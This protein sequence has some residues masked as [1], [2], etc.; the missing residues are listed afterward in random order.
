ME[1]KLQY[2]TRLFKKSTMEKFTEHFCNVIKGVITN[3][4]ITIGDIE[5]L[6]EKE[7]Q[8]IIYDFNDTKTD[9]PKHATM[10]HFFE[11]Q[12]FKSPEKVALK[13]KEK[14]MT[15]IE[16]N[17]KANQLAR[18]LR[19]K[20]VKPNTI[21]GICV[22]RSFEMIIG[23]LG[24]LKAGGAYL[25]IDP[26]YPVERIEFM[27]QDTKAKILL[28]SSH[29]LK[30]VNFAG[31][32][33]VLDDL[34]M[35]AYVSHNLTNYNQP[36]DLA[37]IIYTSGSTG[38][39]KGVMI[40][41]QSIF[42]T[43]KWRTR[44]YQFAEN[45]TIL[46]IPSFAFDSSVEDIFATLISGSKLVLIEQ[47]NRLNLEYLNELMLKNKVT[48]FLITPN[49]YKTLLEEMPD[50]LTNLKAVTLA[51]E[52]FTKELVKD[53]F[54]K[55]Q[56]VRLF[57]EY[58]PTENSVCSTIYEFNPDNIIITIGKPIDNVKCYI[59]NNKNK[60]QPI[61]VSGELCVSGSGLSRGYLNRPVLTEEKFV[62]NPFNSAEKM[63]RTGDLV[64]WLDNGIIEFLGRT[65]HQV[66]IRGFRIELGEIESHLLKH[67]R[68]KNALVIART[69]QNND[70]YLC[71]Y[72]VE[73]SE[74]SVVELRT[75]LTNI[76]PDYMIPQYFIKLD[77]IPLTSN[78]KVDLKALPESTDKIETGI[79]YVAPTNEIEAKLVDFWLEILNVE[80]IGVNDDFF[81]LG[82]YSLKAMQLSAKVSK[83]FNKELPLRVIF[84]SPNIKGLAKYIL[85]VEKSR[86]EN[87]NVVETREYY[88]LSSAQKRLYVLNQLEGK[89]ISY[90]MPSFVYIEGEY[91][92]T[93]CANVF[94]R[95]IKQHEV[96]RSSFI[97]IDGE[98]V[99][100]IYEDVD[101]DIRYAE[102]DENEI[103]K[104]VK[105]FIQPFDLS[106]A[107]LLRVDLLKIK[108]KNK[109]L[110]MID[111]HHIISD[112]LSMEILIEDFIQLHD[113][114]DLPKLKIQYKD[115]SEWQNN[116]L[117]SDEIKV[118]EKFWLDIFSEEIS[119]LNLPTDYL[120]PAVM[121][122]TGSVSKFHIVRDLADQLKELA[123]GSSTTLYMI[124]LAVYNI[125]LAKYAGQEDIVIGSPIANRSHPDLEKIMGMFVNMLAMR[126]YPTEDK[127]FAEF[128][129][130]VKDNALLAYENQ[131]YQFEM[132]VERL[133]LERDLSR[134]PLFDTVFA[135]QNFNFTQKSAG[136]IKFT[137]YPFEN[138]IA[139]FDLT[140]N[141]V[142][143]ENGIDFDIE[144]RT[145]L[146]KDETIKRM[147]Y[148][149]INIIR[150][151]VKNP[152]ISLKDIEII[153]EE[154]K[155]QILF[156][157]NDTYK[158]NPTDKT[159]T[160]LFEEQVKRNP[161]KLALVFENEKITYQ[162][163]NQKSN[164]LAR[165]LREKGVKT[166][167][168]VGIIVRQGIEMFI[169]ILAIL[170]AR[171]AYL[172]IDP[173]YPIERI[174]YMLADS[175]TCLCLSS[176]KSFNK[177]DFAGEIINLDDEELYENDASN[178]EMIKQ[179]NNLAYVIHTSGSTGKPKGVL[180]EHRS[181]LNLIYWHNDYYQVTEADRS[182]KYAGFG[183]D[184]SVWEIFPYIIKGVTI[185]IISEE[186][187]LD[188]KKLSNYFEENQITISFLPTQ[189][190]EQFMNLEIP[191]LRKLLTGGDRLKSYIKRN[192]QLFNNYGPTEDTVVATA[193]EIT[194]DYANIPIGKPIY[195]TQ[196]Y[197]LGNSNQLQPIGIP[198]ELCISGKSL[199]R[200][201]LNREELT[202]EKFTINPYTNERMYRTGD[203]ARWLPDGSIEFLGRVDQQ[204]KIRGY[205]IEPGEIENQI[206]SHEAVREA[207]VVDIADKYD[208]KY[209]VA[210]IIGEISISD[211]KKYLSKELPDYMIPQYFVI[212]EN[213][214]VTAN[215]KIDRKAL[216]RP[217]I[218]SNDNEYIAPGN[219]T[220]EKLAKIWSEVLGVECV[221]I[222]D[223]FFELGGDSIRAIQIVARA[224]Q[225]GH[226]ITVKDIF[227]YKTI[228][229]ILENVDYRK[230]KF[231][232][233]QDDVEGEV[234]LTPIQNW[235]FHQKFTYQHYWNQSNIFSIKDDVDLELLEEVFRKLIKTHDALRMGY[236]FDD[237]QIVQF[238]RRNDE[239]DFE[240]DVID[241]A[242]YSYKVQKEKIKQISEELQN[243]LDLENDLLIKAFIFDLGSNGK[244]LLIP[245]HHLVIDGV[246]WRILL[247]DLEELYQ[248]KLQKTLPLKTTSF[249]EWSSKLNEY[250][251]E[252]N[253]DIEYWE[254]ID[255]S[256]VK[257]LVTTESEH[258]Y[259]K[260]FKRK[261]IQLDETQT[262]ILLT[263]VNFAYN[264]EINDILL[265][266]LAN[267]LM[268]V[269]ESENL[270]LTLEGHGREE[271]IEDVDISR[272]VGWFTSS[273]PVYFERQE[274]IE[275]SIKYVKEN[276]RKIPDRGINCGIARYLQNQSK[277]QQLNPEISFNY[278]GQ[279]DGVIAKNDK[280]ILNDCIEEIG[281]GIHYENSHVNLIDIIGL[282]INGRLELRVDYN[283]K[284]IQDD[285]IADFM[286]LYK[287]QLLNLIDH[288]VNKIESSVTPSDFRAERI[289]DLEGF[290]LI[291]KRYSNILK[292]NPLT[293]MQE[294]MLFHSLS[295]EKG[296]NYCEQIGYFIDG[297]IDIEM[298]K[299]SWTKTLDRHEIFRTE[300]VWKESKKPVQIVLQDKD[301]EIHEHDIS[302]K[303]S[304]EQEKYI[305][306]F[307]NGDLD[308]G[309][310]IN[311]GKL[312]RLS[313][314]KLSEDK[315]YVC[316][317]F[318]HI[319]LDG[320]S[321]PVVIQSLLEIYYALTTDTKM[322]A[323]S[324]VDFSDY[325]EWYKKHDWRKSK[326]FWKDYLHDF[327][328]PTL[329]PVDKNVSNKEVIT[330]AETVQLEFD[331]E[332]TAKINQ[333]CKKKNITMNALIQTAWGILL[334]KYNN[335]DKSCFGMTVSGRPGEIDGV[336]NIVGLFI[337]TLP[338]VVRNKDGYRIKEMLTDLN[339]ELVEIRE[340]GYISLTEIQKVSNI[341]NSQSLF[342][343]LLVYEN[344][345]LSSVKVKDVG[346]NISFNSIYSLTNYDLAVVVGSNERTTIKLTYNT[347][348]FDSTDIN[349]ISSYLANLIDKTLK[350]PELLVSEL[351]MIGEDEKHDLVVKFNDTKA[352]YP[353]EKTIQQLF[354]ECVDKTP[355][356]IAVIYN[357]QRYTY[358]ELN[359][360]ANYL[361]QVL[362]DKGVCQESVVGILVGHSVEMVVGILGI[363]KVGGVYLPIDLDYPDERIDYML[364]DSG[365]EILLTQSEL[366]KVSNI[367]ID[368]VFLDTLVYADESQNLHQV[369]NQSNLAYIIYTSG[370]TGKPKGVAIEHQ[371]VVNY[372][373]WF[374]HEAKVTQTDLSI[375]LSS[376]AFD[377][378]YTVFWST[379]VSGASL[380]IVS[381]TLYKDGNLLIDYLSSNSITLIKATPSMFNMLINSPNF[382]ANKLN[383]LRMIVLGGEKIRI[384]DLEIYLQHYPEIIFMNHYGPTETTIG[385]LSIMIDQDSLTT[386]AKR[387]TIGKP[388]SNVKAYVLDQNN[389]IQPVG[390]IGELC[391][392]GEGLARG[393]VNNQH[394]T[395][396][397]FIE[398][399]FIKGERL[400]KTGDLARILPDG[401]V[402]FIGR[403][404]H[405]VKIRG[406]RVEVGEIE[407]QLLNHAS[408]QDVV[409]IASKDGDG[410]NY[411][412]AYI[413]GEE[414]VSVLKNYLRKNLPDYMIPAYF[415]QLDHFPMTANG[416]LDR[417]RL[418][419]PQES[420]NL[421]T[422]YIAPTNTLEEKIVE[423]WSDLLE[424][425]KIGIY[426]NFFDLGG[427]SL[428]ATQ[429]VG[430]MFR[431]MNV[432]I[433]LT[434]VFEKPTI[435]ELANHINNIEQSKYVS[436]GKT[437][438][439]EYYPLSSAQMRIFLLHQMS[440]V[441]IGYNVPT[442]LIIEGNLDYNR[443]EIAINELVRRHEAFRTSFEL[444]DGV[445][446]Q[447]IQQDVDLDI[448]YLETAEDEIE[449]IVKKFM[450]SFDL[451]K[452]PL[453]RV[454]L[455]KTIDKYFFISDMHHSISD[456]FSRGILVD[457]FIN[458]YA[459]TKLLDL[460]IQ[461]KD[462][463]VWQ[464]E[465]FLSEKFKKQENYW[466]ER[467]AG[468]LPILNMPTDFPRP[469]LKG[470]EGDVVYQTLDSQLT[471]SLSELVSKNNA[472]QFMILLAAYTVLL[473]RYTGQEDIV[474]G[475]PIAGREHA[476]LENIIG[477]FVNTLA[478]RNNVSDDKT[479]VEF[480]NDV[481]QSCLEA[482]ENQDYQFEMLVE[483][484]SV[485]RSLSRNPLFDTMLVLQNR[486]VKEIAIPDLKFTPYDFTNQV[487]KFDFTLQVTE[488]ADGLELALY[489]WTKLFKRETIER[490]LNNFTVLL[491]NI[492]ENPTLKLSEIEIISP[493]E[494]QKLIYDFNNTKNDI[495]E[496]TI[497]Q[498]F[499]EQVQ[500]HSAE[501]A[502]T[503]DRQNLTYQELNERANQLARTLR[504]KGLKPDQVAGIMVERSLKMAVAIFAI[505]KAGGAYLPIDTEYPEERINF[506][507]DDSRTNLLLSLR[508]LTETIQFT[509][510]IIFLDDEANYHQ[511]VNN[512]DSINQLTDLA[513]II[514]TSGTTGKPKGVMIEHGSIANTIYWFKN[515]YQMSSEDRLLQIVSF[516]FDAFLISFFGTLS[517]G[518]QIV[519]VKDSES[520]DLEVLLNY[521]VTKKITYLLCPPSL[522]MKLLENLT[523]EEAASLKVIIMGGEAIT[524]KLIEMSRNFNPNIEMVNEYGPTENSITSTVHRN[525]QDSSQVTI[526]KPIANTQIYIFDKNNQLTPIGVVGELCLSGVGLSRGYLNRVDLTNEKFVFNPYAKTRMYRTGDLGRWLPDGSIQ[527]LGR[528]DHQV[529][530]RGF[531]IELGEI[532]AQ[533]LEFKSIKDA[534]VI[535]LKDADGM[536]YLCAY[537]VTE[538]EVLV[539]DVRLFLA[540]RVPNYM[541]PAHIIIL[542]EMPH[543]PNG[544]ID[545]KSLP[546]PDGRVTTEYVAPTNKI[547]ES[548]VIIWSEVLGTA[549]VGIYD[550]FF[551]L[552][553]HSL[554]G[555][556]IA[557]KMNQTFNIEISLKDIFKCPTVKELAEFVSL[558]EEKRFSSIEKVEDREYYPLSSAQKRLFILNQLE[559]ET[560]SYNMPNLMLID[561]DLSLERLEKAF[562]DLVERHEA[563]RTSFDLV[564]GEPMQKVHKDLEFNVEYMEGSKREAEKII[565]EFIRPFDLRKAPLFRVKV[566]K[567]VDQYLLMYDMHHIISDGISITIL[568]NEWGRLYL[569]REL[570]DLRIQYK[571]FAVWQNH[572]SQSPGIK[573]QEEFWLEMFTGEIPVLNM[574][575]DFSRPAEICFKGD[576]IH[577]ELN[578]KL[579]TRLIQLSTKNGTTLYMTLLS[580]F[581]ILLSKY[582]G[583]EDIVIG[584]PSAGR[585]HAELDQ[586]IGLFINTLAIRAY[587][588][589]SKTFAE[590]LQEIKEN[591][592]RVYNNQD[593]PFERLVEKLNIE[594]DLSRSPLFDVMFTMQ[595]MEQAEIKIDELKFTPYQVA[596]K[597]SKF[598]ITL[599][600]AEINNKI[601]F[602]LEYSI[603]LYQKETMQ[604]LLSHFVNILD[605]ITQNSEIELRDI[606]L[607]APEE[608]NELLFDFNDTNKEYPEKE[609]IYQL[610]EEHVE[611]EPDKIAVCFEDQKIS[612]RELNVKANQLARVLQEKGVQAD[613][614]VG[615]IMERSIE[616]ITGI[617]GILKAGGAYLPIDSGYLAERIEYMIKDSGT[618]LLITKSKLQVNFDLPIEVI[619]IE[620]I[621]SN[622][623]SSNLAY[624]SSSNN[625]AYIIYTS[626][627]TGNPKGVA[628]EHASLVNYTHWF[629]ET[630][631]IS[632]K[633]SSALLSSYAFDLGYTVIWS[634]LGSGAELHLVAE[635]LYKDAN[636]LIDYLIEHKI[637]F[638]KGTPSLFNMLVNSSRFADHNLSELRLIVLGGEKIRANDLEIYHQKY[639]EVTFMN[640]YGPTEATI[641]C[642]SH[643]INKDSL[644]KFI[645]KP[646]IGTSNSNTKAYILDSQKKLVPV[647]VVGE[648]YIA[649]K[650]LARGYLNRLQLT[651]ERF[652]EN[653]YISGER[654]YKT[655]DLVRWMPNGMIDFIG[656][657]DHQVKIRGFR[658]E[659]GEIEKQLANHININEAVVI[660]RE[661]EDGIDL[662]AYIVESEEVVISKLREYLLRKLPEYMIP[663][664]FIKLDKFPLTENGKLNLKAL[665]EPITN[666]ARDTD[667]V[668]PTNPLE[669][670]MV[671]LWS[672]VLRIEAI[673]VN[674]N[675]FELGGHSLKATVLMAKIHQILGID[676]PLKVIFKHPTIKEL[677]L[678][679]EEKKSENSFSTIE[680]ADEKEYY[681]LSS[682]QKRLLL[683]SQLNQD[684]TTYNMP[685][686]MLIEGELDRESLENAFKKLVQRHDSLR[687]SFTI[688]DGEPVQKIEESVDLEISYVETDKTIE[689]VILEFIRPFDLAKAPLLRVSVAKVGSKNIFLCDMHHI[690]SDGISR[691]ILLQ[692]FISL[693]AGESVPELKLQYKDFAVWQNQF[694][695]TDEFKNQ[696]KYWLERF[697]DEVSV[698]NLPTDYSRAEVV[699]FAG[700]VVSFL[701]EEE[702]TTKLN[703]LAFQNNATLYMVLLA[704]YNILLSKYSRQEDIVIGS[705]IAGR[706]HAE[707]ANIMGVFINTLAMRN[708]PAKAKTFIQFLNEV[709]GNSLKAYENQDYQY[710]M[711]VDKLNIQIDTIFLMQ[712][713][714]IVEVKIP[715]LR[716]IPIDAE[717]NV[718]KFDLTLTAVE[719]DSQIA[720]NFGFRTSLYN[721]TTIE[722]MA[723][724]FVRI[725]GQI[726]ENPDIL[727]KEINLES[728]LKIVESTEIDFEFGF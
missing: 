366:R 192:Y 152:D 332:K 31:V 254:K 675:F 144:Y 630:G 701:I 533:L 233:S 450:Q 408:V 203:L 340:D 288:C 614:S 652:I 602:V 245:I 528:I 176:K 9:N 102:I 65:D 571:D 230:K 181:L 546:K 243:N 61:G 285:L 487:A 64:R 654:L 500:K 312:N 545:R 472:T 692:E 430:R 27:L 190:C 101:F 183:F 287:E 224:S 695:Q 129:A 532:E 240:L 277:L 282:C 382:I 643:L 509:G 208:N 54:E 123:S 685:L 105:K 206:L 26:E 237:D 90:N 362:R 561:G 350:N 213:M 703:E 588:K 250:A 564:N 201:Y 216:P 655:G 537:I 334:Q 723:K 623:K 711:L 665:P 435:K 678:Y 458:L 221:G 421:D 642:I 494:K 170:K 426:D 718:A 39:P 681:P 266:A 610:F 195:N 465:F 619:D 659:L 94:V 321:G 175:Q 131:D 310:D 559:S 200:G 416:K 264:T 77:K 401:M 28:A 600:A 607:L 259:W 380:H 132:L 47:K 635:D 286:M 330:K 361:A 510:E 114:N 6:S 79:H 722:E 418:P 457:E 70:K 17:E 621:P 251:K 694:F 360:K 604:R 404:D 704:A 164:Q 378:G 684:N 726:T 363:L 130:E 444:I 544:K 671:K 560:T 644:V 85:G 34:D 575:T 320:W 24:I 293:P 67:E 323:K 327:T 188:I 411:L 189:I 51:G 158:D 599:R 727:L 217:E 668:I 352:D 261:N 58:G 506:I 272:T 578:Q 475:S 679:M 728:S 155:K 617:L 68:I 118:Q 12:V 516:A 113:G 489:Y 425:E 226:N 275:K 29:Q 392:S 476:D 511:D 468:E 542:E 11:E 463:T 707:L 19:D 673:G 174:R 565:S 354:E 437:E 520:K 313:L 650:G 104:S 358:R 127:T 495:V 627:S 605:E 156:T 193:C 106:Q 112:G 168:I 486:N 53:H 357:D 348:L 45:D 721:K 117:Q 162:L 10:H 150:E 91:S 492:I 689:E 517:S 124:L 355:E 331:Q 700:D 93:T 508:H 481:R 48:H 715:G 539:G 670:E 471:S 705:P 231:T 4:E 241:F 18:F 483:K 2:A 292:I 120:R 381:D 590:F 633:D 319:V 86:Y 268:E 698:L 725:L 379:L 714:D 563:L 270:L 244:R 44:Y 291:A 598:D 393:Y 558:A 569:R 110:L 15:Y 212:L 238:N 400:Y 461:Y 720:C 615:L 205:R 717:I 146:F 484:L 202:K 522:Y 242:A 260:Y 107:P 531:R 180:V 389:Q 138:K 552:G 480:L 470:Y 657:I 219:E 524:T 518:G 258:N 294:G 661:E 325:L 141:A 22:E 566:L 724:N 30:E 38:K 169:G 343:T 716:L 171:G 669:K 395:N 279:F 658:V 402:E 387:P 488:G 434:A 256:K 222:S 353:K 464:N 303:D 536:Q 530:V 456:G 572:R 454:G 239:I 677:T 422:K 197:I 151:V 672:E 40:E 388:N 587:P 173:E 342:N 326:K 636:Q 308:N 390:V 719:R 553:G 149:Y 501:I 649:G 397:R 95:L 69:D 612:F 688:I 514:Y 220:E 591:F 407:K 161:D 394:L 74:I 82:G 682:A 137:P 584:S 616:M 473:S 664:Y 305:I 13:Y 413:I 328:E 111:M 384:N 116:F 410:N 87:I 255:T 491:A 365:T 452:A 263:K 403:I 163:L 338:V 632:A 215:G 179:I 301:V 440:E 23:L 579:T 626:G 20:G 52:S 667:Y 433:S 609:T 367:E 406:F 166:D 318:H 177:I 83:E 709:R 121:D 368:R 451:S 76:L 583:Q 656:R 398:S 429:L 674:D 529:K 196:I 187:R 618:E 493:E 645:E 567:I 72:I 535:D 119:V 503:F 447:K 423:I 269:M 710:E 145:T 442:T 253:I 432:E 75:Y 351:E 210:Y 159:I 267:S 274:N 431:E 448:F 526:G 204:V 592:L 593:Y 405:Q 252:E 498:L 589:S 412:T 445:P 383:T 490:L 339:R 504:L 21:V 7:K 513:Y 369:S 317:T 550:N 278:L 78:G 298:F 479:F 55:L 502:I 374:I 172:P 199:V 297:D 594:R 218:K 521:I 232:I 443:F 611:R 223:N 519:L 49:F 597:E 135:L 620:S 639:P 194:E 229:N 103:A 417:K 148:H 414:A 43:L 80:K 691:S 580:A 601:K 302:D 336:E 62:Q 35:E 147:G 304:I 300:F 446:V 653:P 466:L 499:E 316:W 554:K 420:I 228:T 538:E 646:V 557:S 436:I 265:T 257:S 154:E 50:G 92:L 347:Q 139:K 109:H 134:N 568:I 88:T 577:F 84:N 364:H 496:T 143:T 89:N 273:Y 234:L 634:S 37:Y 548:I 299:K 5:I 512:L 115:F 419:L 73:V 63:Y 306:E 574:P 56:N 586:I 262:E 622:Y 370:S 686:V 640:H 315:Y 99:Q 41:H 178:L 373:S 324:S 284:Y 482:F 543:T 309:L 3:P 469:S 460:K 283:L 246:S 441:N 637:T 409:I 595:N 335:T 467:F 562:K 157:F 651:D 1:F 628:I 66:K 455:L 662:V 631:E 540:N 556:S 153:S 525:I 167:Q 453:L 439:K 399:P 81:A 449:E 515:E 133:G 625:L 391:I 629:I 198:G 428:K 377:L 547:E 505:L 660:T 687:T 462:F 702:L 346:F 97:L 307:K 676:I 549:K 281:T 497:Y 647:G 227:R 271:I 165:M 100:I 209:L 311:K 182:T 585:F 690:I 46:Q 666:I 555:A 136:N 415:V 427:H 613:T 42:N 603:S 184:A 459:G 697:K 16:L 142:D 485:E 648:L 249:K 356:N 638:I 375:L 581:Y 296:T 25:P 576:M 126:N 280:S 385:C 247:E 290:E 683:I 211:L 708:I 713:L 699:D 344:Y 523:V 191:S 663:S 527:F 478:L 128:I 329:L 185:Y 680:K 122:F 376:Y 359:A 349:L 541:V 386:F 345:P 207:V 98:P 214:P 333:F 534:L 371:S 596:E 322:S 477:M 8:Q 396:E 438:E 573:K 314:I 551:E 160:Q 14:E 235:F 706:S 140:L 57:N 186:M 507:L 570:T 248:S 276:L 337:N 372:L 60:V 624:S 608:K 59:L 289:F 71:A 108:D 295:N 236:K 582:S 712:N 96:L 474:V 36:N 341:D 125:L 641:G 33:I 225:R 606:E 693:Y 696:E 424:V 32:T